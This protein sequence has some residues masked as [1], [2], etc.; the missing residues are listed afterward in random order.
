MEKEV[1]EKI[2]CRKKGFKK[3]YAIS[4]GALVIVLSAKNA[5]LKI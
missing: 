1:R 2:L 5:N 4:N 3:T